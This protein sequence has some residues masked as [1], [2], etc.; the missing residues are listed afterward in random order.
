LAYWVATGSALVGAVVRGK[1]AAV[2]LGTAGVGVT[3][4]L[5]TLAALIATLAALGIGTGGMKIIAA[6]RAQ[7]DEAELHR[8]VSLVVWAP[9]AGGVLA[10]IVAVVLARPLSTLLL[11]DPTYASLV[12]VS[13]A[14]IPFSCLLASF[15]V[16]MQGYELAR[17]LAVTSIVAAALTTAA[18]VP[19]T[20]AYGVEGAVAATPLAA[21]TTLGFFVVREPW[22]LRAA[23]PLT[24]PVRATQRELGRL[25]SASFIASALTLGTDTVL[26][27]ATVHRLGLAENG[28]YQPAQTYTAVLLAQVAGAL[29]LVLLP[30]LTYELGKGREEQVWAT[31][32]SAGRSAVVLA[33]PLCLMSAA[34]SELFILV[35]FDRS[36]LPAADVLGVQAAGE[37]PR[38]L[39]YVLGAVL[40]PAGLVREW[41]AGAVIANVVRLGLGLVL[42]PSLGLYALAI[43]SVAMWVVTLVWTLHVLRTRLTWRPGSELLRLFMVGSLL[44]AAGVALAFTG[45]VGKVA[46]V[47]AAIAWLLLVGRR[48]LTLLAHASGLRRHP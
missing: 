44:V 37:L 45:P 24:L 26:R 33:V 28:L 48:E 22:L 3:A 7:G 6:A 10:F 2:V 15:Q 18:A 42:L 35:L 20:I 39:S 36:F 46:I 21:A 29:S 25:A 38:F 47:V 27:S 30:R 16:V 32:R 1:V 34:L 40:L 8:V 9:L 43:G 19:L 5:T 4:Q 14:S 11:G 31:L 17:R 23:F 12:I 41:V 13:M